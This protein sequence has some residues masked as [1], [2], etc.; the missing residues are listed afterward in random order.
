MKAETLSW[1]FILYMCFGI[2]KKSICIEKAYGNCSYTEI[3]HFGV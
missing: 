2:K 1:L 3:F